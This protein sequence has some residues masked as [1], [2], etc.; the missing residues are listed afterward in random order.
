M[1]P[2]NHGE[3]IALMHS[4]LSEGLEGI[5]KGLMDDHLPDRTMIECELADVI[6]RIMDYAAHTKLDV[7]GAIIAKMIYNSS[8]PHRHGGKKF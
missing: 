2:F 6:I 4:E 1:P 5:R 3:K 8:R 7:A